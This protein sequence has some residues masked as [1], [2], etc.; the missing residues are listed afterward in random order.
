MNYNID[1]NSEQTVALFTPGIQQNVV[2]E[3]VRFEPAD[4]EGKKDKVLRFVFKGANG[5]KHIETIFQINKENTLAAAAKFGRNGAEFLQEEFTALAGKVLHIMSTYVP[6][7]QTYFQANSWEEFCTGVITR[8]GE[9]YKNVPVRIKLVLNNKDCL[10]L[11][12]KAKVPFIQKMSEAN[13]LTINPKWD[14]VVYTQKAA[15]SVADP[16]AG[17]FGTAPAATA[18]ASNAGDPFVF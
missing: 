15:A 4:K 7:E 1:Q 2:L 10:Q 16:F 6:K 9:S 17:V 14:K 5:E 12:R 11:P 13:K 3:E 8:L 18:G